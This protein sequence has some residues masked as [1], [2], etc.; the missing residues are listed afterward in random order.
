[1]RVGWRRERRK[2]E[3]EGNKAGRNGGRDGTRDGGDEGIRKEMA[4]SSLSETSAVTGRGG[5][6]E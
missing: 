4:Q 1:M 3:D 2:E 5:R 6:R